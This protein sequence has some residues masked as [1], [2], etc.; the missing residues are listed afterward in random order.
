[1][2]YYLEVYPDE[3]QL[4]EAVGN[5]ETS[6]EGMVEQEAGWL[7]A[8]G[9]GAGDCM[10]VA[11]DDDQEL[12]DKVI[13][14]IRKQFQEGDLTVLDEMLKQLPIQCLEATLPE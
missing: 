14:D 3:E 8:S 5:D 12:V 11:G 7:S 9:I 10:R 6:I 4:Q 1:M 13:E 2:K